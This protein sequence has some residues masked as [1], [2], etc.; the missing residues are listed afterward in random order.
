MSVVDEAP[1]S[2][3]WIRDVMNYEYD[4]CAAAVAAATARL[5][6][7]APRRIFRAR[8]RKTLRNPFRI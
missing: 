3:L 6:S 1:S 7:E 5:V 8:A 2:T 4:Q